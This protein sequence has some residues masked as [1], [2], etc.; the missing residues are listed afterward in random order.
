MDAV[1]NG[2]PGLPAF[3]VTGSLLSAS[4]VGA[5]LAVVGD[6]LIRRT[7]ITL[8]DNEAVVHGVFRDRRVPWVRV[9]AV[10][11]EKKAGHS[12]LLWMDNRT[13]IR[14]AQPSALRPDARFDGLVDLIG[15]HWIGRR[16]PGWA[17]AWPSSPTSL[18]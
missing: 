16:G 17:P 8:H 6:R 10:T 1:L 4:A 5:A 14:L 15:R 18:S 9:Q 12:V 7:G 11:V 13:R 3:L 2:S